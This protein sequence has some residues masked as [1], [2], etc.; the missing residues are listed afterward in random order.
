MYKM[1]LISAEGYKN[2][3]V[4]SDID[5]KNLS[6]LVLEEIYGISETKNPTKKQVNEYKMTKRQIYKKFTNLSD[7]ELNAKNNKKMYVRN[8]VM[9]TTI[10]RCKGEKTRGIRAID[11]FRK[12][13]MIPDFGIP[14][15]PEF[16]VK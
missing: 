13:L 14:K 16:E 9:T 7:K 4:G 2:A 3:N 5:V 11:G 6:D 15:C 8:D 1:Y 12:K 10:K